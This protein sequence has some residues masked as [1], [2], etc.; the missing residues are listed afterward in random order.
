MLTTAWH[1]NYSSQYE[2][3][4][5]APIWWAFNNKSDVPSVKWEADSGKRNICF[6]Y[7]RTGLPARTKV[8]GHLLQNP[9][10]SLYML[11][12]TWSI[13]SLELLL[14]LHLTE[15][16]SF[17]SNTFFLLKLQGKFCFFF[18]FPKETPLLENRATLR[19][20]NKK[21]KINLK[22][23]WRHVGSKVRISQ[24]HTL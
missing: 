7:H 8:H 13:W 5:C 15:I 16:C 12:I 3:V 14:S 10:L 20:N 18:F 23:N 6:P 17:F 24:Y 21:K 4:T 9:E 2:C 22:R 19:G 1:F 11:Y